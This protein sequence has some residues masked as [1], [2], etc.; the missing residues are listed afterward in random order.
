LLLSLLALLLLMARKYKLAGS[1]LAIGVALLYLCST[2]F[3]ADSMMGWLERDYPPRSMAQ[4]PR[5]DGILLLG[6]AMRGDVQPLAELADLNQQADRLV[7]AVALYR[8]GKAPFIMLTGGSASDARTEAEMMR[9]ILHV[10]GIPPEA[11]VLETAS[12]DTH[13]NAVLSAALI[14]ERNWQRVLL[15]TSS[16][17]M[18]RAVALFKAQGI[19]VI[20]APTDH[21]RLQ[22]SSV[23]PDWLPS[24]SSLSRTTYA[25]HELL[26]YLVYR[27]RGWL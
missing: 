20:P 16:W 25:L 17:H 13:D 2:A 14:R 15:V 26:G 21:Q 8:A 7:H 12:L 19:D 10:M 9:D 22:G 11:L 27:W 18:P 4:T 3:V 24:V 1:S 23:L 5:A 6:G